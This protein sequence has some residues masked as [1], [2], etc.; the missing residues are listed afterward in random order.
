MNN[1]NQTGQIFFIE[2]LGTFSP[3]DPITTR[4]STKWNSPETWMQKN[5]QIETLIFMSTVLKDT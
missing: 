5:N 1:L 4:T 3:K 2:Y